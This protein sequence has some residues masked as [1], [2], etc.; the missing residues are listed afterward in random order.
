MSNRDMTVEYEFHIKRS[1]R[2]RKHVR[3]GSP[4][5]RAADSGGAGRVPRITRLVALAI[6]LDD[7]VR[8]GQVGS[9]AEIARLAGITRARVSQIMNLLNLAPDLQEAILYMSRI[10]YGCDPIPES[11]VRPIA[12]EPDWR[13]QRKMWHS[14]ERRLSRGNRRT[15]TKNRDR[16]EGVMST[17]GQVPE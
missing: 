12:A 7:L 2:G 9:Y 8:T 3:K 1:D 11:K 15:S 10:G 13:V 4:S 5:S 14:E 6:R 17:F 16:S